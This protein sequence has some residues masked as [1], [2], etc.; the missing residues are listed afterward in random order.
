MNFTNLTY[1]PILSFLLPSSAD[2]QNLLQNGLSIDPRFSAV[3]GNPYLRQSNSSLPPLPP[4]S[5]ANPSATPAPPP[6]NSVTRQGGL[7]MGQQHQQQN[8]LTKSSSSNLSS[9]NLALVNL[10]GSNTNTL[11]SNANLTSNMTIATTNL[12]NQLSGLGGSSPSSGSTST[13]T[14]SNG[15]FILPS[16]G[17]F[18]KTGSLATHV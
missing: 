5:T 17:T 14:T 3:Y 9:S 12:S 4:P 8:L 2:N 11:Q 15:Q 1:A 6:Y 7:V 16:N 10:S 13:T 18:K